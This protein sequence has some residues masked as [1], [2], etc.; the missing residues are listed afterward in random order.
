MMQKIEESIVNTLIAVQPSIAH[1]HRSCQSDDLANQVCFEILGFDFLL[2]YKLKP[3][4]IEINH[5]P[6]FAIDSP[7]DNI[8]KTAVVEDA[9][10]L[11][12]IVPS[13]QKKFG[14][15]RKKLEKLVKSEGAHCADGHIRATRLHQ[16][17]DIADKLARNRDSFEDLNCGG[18]KKIYPF[19]N[20]K[21]DELLQFSQKMFSMIGSKSS[22]IE[23]TELSPKIFQPIRHNSK[24][25]RQRAVSRPRAVSRQRAVS[26]CRTNVN[27]T[28]KSSNDIDIVHR[29]SM[30]L[31]C[32][33]FPPSQLTSVRK[34][35]HQGATLVGMDDIRDIR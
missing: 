5:S 20:N 6:S 29:K 27:L 22:K 31:P 25:A 7:L 10:T 33:D 28:K 15:H 17:N 13:N 30:T 23:S 19:E 16:K 2:D 9:L 12:N 3:W 26:L 4:L 34:L 1:L 8:V 24:S 35:K 32:I 11:I 18:Y 21:Y 14:K